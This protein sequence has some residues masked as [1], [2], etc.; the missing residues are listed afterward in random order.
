MTDSAWLAKLKVGDKVLRVCGGGW[1]GPN[2]YA[3]TVQKVGKLHVTVGGRK[4]RI[5]GGRQAGDPYASRIEQFDKEPLRLQELD[6]ER[7]RLANRM[8]DIRWRDIDLET[9]KAIAALLP[10]ETKGGE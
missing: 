3:E 9:L 8:D 2:F 6:R 7:C 5:D 4:Y 10:Q 1:G